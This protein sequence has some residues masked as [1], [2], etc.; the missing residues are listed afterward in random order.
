MTL[1]EIQAPIKARYADEPD[2]A[3]ITLT[4]VGSE[5]YC[6]VLQTLLVPPRI[7]AVW[8]VG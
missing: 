3:R 2:A 1:R 8:D 5:K 6:V 4:A 7:E